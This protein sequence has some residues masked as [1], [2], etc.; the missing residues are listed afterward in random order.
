M[1]AAYAQEAASARG[2]HMRGG[3]ICAEGWLCVGAAYAQGAG[4]A[5]EQVVPGLNGWRGMGDV[6]KT[7]VILLAGLGKYIDNLM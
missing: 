4:Y 3:C 1:G 6:C 2:L 5:W 7:E